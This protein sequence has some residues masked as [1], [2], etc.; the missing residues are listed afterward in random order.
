MPCGWLPP[1]FHQR[2]LPECMRRVDGCGEVAARLGGGCCERARGRVGGGGRTFVGESRNSGAH[3]ALARVERAPP[4]LTAQRSCRYFWR[5]RG[6]LLARLF[7]AVDRSRKWGEVAAPGVGRASSFD[8]QRPHSRARAP[9][10]PQAGQLS[11]DLAP[12]AVNKVAAHS[13]RAKRTAAILSNE[14]VRSC[15][16]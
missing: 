2:N 12:G 10:G 7:R 14:V 4:S 11:A 1:H 5:P 3:S 15:D 13:A 9:G 6:R 8:C 16:R